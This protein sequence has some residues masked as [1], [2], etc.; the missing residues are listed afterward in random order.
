M[1]LEPYLSGQ[2]VEILRKAILKGYDNGKMIKTTG[3][4][5]SVHCL[6]F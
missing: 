6:A 1:A 5:D 4:L 3:F 2:M